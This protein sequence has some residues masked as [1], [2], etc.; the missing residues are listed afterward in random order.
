M[1]AEPT[2]GQRGELEA[3][4]DNA[5]TVIQRF[6]TTN[7]VLIRALSP[8]YSPMEK[9]AYISNPGRATRE[10]QIK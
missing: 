7:A 10:V 2:V 1:V 8:I 6:E 4:A 5:L 3:G 9:Q